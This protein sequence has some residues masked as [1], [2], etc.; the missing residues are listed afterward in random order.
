MIPAHI[1]KPAPT[2]FYAL[3]R[4]IYERAL[5]GLCLVGGMRGVSLKEA[6]Q[7]VYMKL[8][9]ATL[10]CGVVNILVTARAK[11][12]PVI[13][14]HVHQIVGPREGLAD[15]DLLAT[16]R[17][18]FSYTLIVGHWQLDSQAQLL[19]TP[20]RRSMG[21]MEAPQQHSPS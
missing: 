10:W 21:S 17:E 1:S 7:I 19:G 5:R 2:T 20:R 4:A 15:E 18:G 14:Q 16:H 3:A 11:I 6:V 9:V 13:A 8:D 12:F